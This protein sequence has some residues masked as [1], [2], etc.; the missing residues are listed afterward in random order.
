M[1]SRSEHPF[2]SVVAA[3]APR[4][5]EELFLFI[6]GPYDDAQ[7][8]VEVDENGTP[9]EIRIV[10]DI[11]EPNY[12]INSSVGLQSNNLRSLYTRAERVGPDGLVWVFE[13]SV[14]EVIDPNKQRRV[15]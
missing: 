4:R 14:Q 2:F 13:Y 12:A 6:G 11:T 15:A 3:V 1:T 9:D 7:M 5:R 8:L 10:E